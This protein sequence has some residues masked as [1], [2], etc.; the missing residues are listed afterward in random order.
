MAHRFFKAAKTNWRFF[1]TLKSP[2]KET[3]LE[4]D[5][6]LEELTS[7]INAAASMT[8]EEMQKKM[9]DMFGLTNDDMKAL[10][11]LRDE[12]DPGKF[13]HEPRPDDDV[14]T[15]VQVG[16]SQC[17]LTN[18]LKRRLEHIPGFPRPVKEMRDKAYRISP[19]LHRGLGMFA[20]RRFKTGDLV[21][22][23]RPLMVFPVGPPTDFDLAT[24]K[25]PGENRIK[26]T[27]KSSDDIL[28]S[29]FERMSEESQEAFMG[30]QNSHLPNGL[31]FGTARTNGYGLEDGL[32][33][34]TENVKFFSTLSSDDKMT[35]LVQ[36]R[37]GTY[38]GVF[39]DLSRVNHSCSPNIRRKFY[40]SSFSM[41]LRAARDI[42]E[43]EEIF[44]TYT[45]DLRPAADRAKGL[46][47]YGIKC[48]C[49]ACLD[50]AKSDPIRAAVLNYSPPILLTSGGGARD[51]AVEILARIE[52]EGL[53][54][55]DAYHETLDQLF[56]AYAYAQD[57]K[58]ALMY[59][60]KLW[61]ANLAAGE[62]LYE[63]FRNVEVMKKTPQWMTGEFEEVP[64]RL[65]SLFN[66]S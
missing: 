61:L 31:L 23:E 43:G 4:L 24:A 57:E 48:T 33:D 32:K 28:S 6:Q 19:T 21:A 34:E 59:G 66:A 50:P 49:R 62:P 26:L 8:P 64:E 53:Q 56:N 27:L 7:A 47:P 65:V 2:A 17:L 1:S 20:A 46:A 63:M 58:N 30:L 41:Q 10:A 12:N 39:K 51:A 54:A 16:D 37:I 44:T 40:M 35:Q 5:R 45:Q 60:E 3:N 13:E 18:Y 11:P 29:I 14:R 9:V 55:S 42:E 22:D 52:E 36:S 25:V 38:A 15:H